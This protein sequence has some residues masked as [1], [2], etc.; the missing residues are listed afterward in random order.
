MDKNQDC[1][2]KVGDTVIIQAYLNSCYN[3]YKGALA[4]IVKCN[5]NI[6]TISICTYTG[7]KLY[8]VPVDHLKYLS[9]EN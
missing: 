1:I 8:Q 4:E 3:I 7:Y 5:K 2:F 9:V 6:V